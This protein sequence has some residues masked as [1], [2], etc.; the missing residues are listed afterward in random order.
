MGRAIHKLTALQ[1]A[2]ITAPGL[3]LD[4]GGLYL[5]V[6]PS[7]SKKWVFRYKRRDMG[8]GGYPA[9]SLAEARQKA[10]EA[11]EV[12]ARGEDPIEVRKAEEAARKPKPILTFDEAAARYI[13]AHEAAWRNP[14]H[15][16]QWRNTLATYASPVIGKMDVAAID[17]SHILDILEPIW[18]V[19]TETA[20]R[21]RGRLETV[22]DWCKVR[23]YRSGENPAR[24]RGHLSHLLPARSKITAVE[25]HASLPYADMPA[26]MA[27]LRARDALAARALA[28]CI[29]TAT[30]TSE[31]LEAE[32][33]EIDLAGKVW[34]VP[35]ARMKNGKPHRVPLSDDAITLLAHLPRIDGSDY[36]F[37]GERQNRPLSNM[38][39]LM[40]LRRMGRGE[41]T[42]HGFRTSFRTW[43]AECTPFPREVAEMALSHTVGSAVERAYQRGDLFAKRRRLMEAWG[44]YIASLGLAEER[45]EQLEGEVLS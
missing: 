12:L 8:L 27:E 35:A 9:V 3:H 20:S 43:A 2:K 24:W 5:A 28:F 40:L 39:F 13:A 45:P 26:F 18:R 33:F 21:L 38:A 10:A 15:R 42:A 30:R 16:Q 7:G 29:L 4:G 32:W 31:T 36:V 34:T 11:R 44:D 14:K 6:A 41:L 17:T 25:H 37:P 1:V 19:K 23:Q 22:L